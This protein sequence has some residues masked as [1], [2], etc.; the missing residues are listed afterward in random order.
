MQHRHDEGWWNSL[1]C[2]WRGEL[3]RNERLD[4]QERPA[5]LLL[6]CAAPTQHALA[7]QCNTSTRLKLPAVRGETQGKRPGQA[8]VTDPVHRQLPVNHLLKISSPPFLHLQ[9][10]T[11]AL[12]KKNPIPKTTT[13]TKSKYLTIFNEC[14]KPSRWNTSQNPTPPK[15]H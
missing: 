5:E 13:I 4:P 11:T 12:Y 9:K 10:P 3:Q 14:F 2:K 7:T 8:Q 1:F 6:G 15:C